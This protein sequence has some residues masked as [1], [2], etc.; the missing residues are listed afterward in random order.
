MLLDIVEFDIAPV[1]AGGVALVV[2]AGGGAAASAGGMVAV[3][4]ASAAGVV[5]S[6]AFFWQAARLR[7]KTPAAA[8]VR[9]R[10]FIWYGLPLG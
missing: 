8:T 1:S 2:S 4:D 9:M 6:S 7:A 5:V 3:A 10:S